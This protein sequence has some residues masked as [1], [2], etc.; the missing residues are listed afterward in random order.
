MRLH[1]ECEN[2]V[3]KLTGIKAELSDFMGSRVVDDNVDALVAKL[4]LKMDSKWGSHLI[5]G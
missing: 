1:V 5:H 4:K 2:V 3:E